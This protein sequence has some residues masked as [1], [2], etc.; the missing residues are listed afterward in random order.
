M[1]LPSAPRAGLYQVILSQDAWIDVVQDGKYMRSVGSTAGGYYPR[2]RKS[3]RLE[4]G[5]APFALQLSAIS[6]L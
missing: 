5:H 2:L 4:L 1:R 6:A 3:V